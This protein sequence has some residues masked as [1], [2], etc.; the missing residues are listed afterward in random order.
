MNPSVPWESLGETSLGQFRFLRVWNR[1][2]RRARDGREADFLWLDTP[3]WVMTLALTAAGEVLLV[4]QYRFGSGEFSW[5]PPG[6]IVDAGEDPVRAGARELREETGYAAESYVD[7]GW[8]QPNPALQKNKAFFVLA[9]NCRLA[10]SPALDEYED[11]EVKAFPLKEAFAMAAD[12]RIRHA[13][14]VAALFKLAH[15]L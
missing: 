9:K 13:G 4:R 10:G 7:M 1:R 14:A 2:M 15:F 5:E 8:L 6:G 12:G 11:I 3:D